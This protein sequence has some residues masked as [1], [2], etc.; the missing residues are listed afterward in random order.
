MDLSCAFVTCIDTPDHVVEAERLGYHRAWA[1]DSPAITSDVW[2]ALAL[3]A[4]RT[5]TIGLGPGVLVPSL[6]HPMTNAAA[7]AS[8]VCLAPGRVAVAVGSGF[9][10]RYTLGQRPLRWSF[11]EDYVSVL[12]GL[13]RGETVEWEGAPIRMLHSDG[14]VADRRVDVAVYIGADGPKGTAVADR[15]GDGIFAA[16]VP[17]SAAAGRPH[18]LLQFGTVLETGEDLRS[19]RV[20]AAAGHAIAVVFHA[21]YERG[22]PDAVRRFPGGAAWVRDIEAIAAR[23]RHLVTHEGHLVRITDVD[24]AAVFEAADMLPAF[25]FSGTP[26]QLRD[27]VAALG[28]QGVTEIVYQ[29]AGPDIPGELARMANAIRG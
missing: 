28:A 17:N 22:G 7:I 20:L 6:R 24:R 3:A 8:L 15:V 18:A 5:S 1:Y 26:A 23:E 27:K 25:S 16:G 29:P 9:T 4:T 13:L 11:V 19:E 10:G 12:R 21:T 14:M 2:V